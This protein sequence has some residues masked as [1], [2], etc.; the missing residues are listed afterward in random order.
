MNSFCPPAARNRIGFL[1]FRS[2]LA[3]LYPAYRALKTHL[4]IIPLLGGGEPDILELDSDGTSAFEKQMD[5][6]LN[7][8]ESYPELNVKYEG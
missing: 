5:Y 1:T 2:N 4:K 3:N 8:I 7:L 6:F